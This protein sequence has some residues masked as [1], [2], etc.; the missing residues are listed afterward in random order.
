MKRLCVYCGSN[1]G[2]KPV[3]AEAAR[4]LAGQLV[5]N[6]IE[7][8]YGGG[9]N[10]IMGVLADAVLA[11]G[12]TAIGVIPKA[13]MDKE[14]GHTALSELHIV[15]SMHERKSMM[16]LLSDGFVALPGGFGTLEEI[17]EVLT[18]GQLQFHT[19]PCGLLNVNGYFDDLLRY[20][21]RAM[22]SGF[23]RPQHRAMLLVADQPAGLLHQF[24]Q[25]VPPSA[26]KWT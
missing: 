3:F 19:K 13:L 24:S 2:N 15:D 22:A 25:Y 17:I 20:L 9:A 6:R 10:G 8:V 11:A 7:L 26:E 21:D 14:I 5:A 23:I 16:A 18:W 12:G 4:Q 1:K